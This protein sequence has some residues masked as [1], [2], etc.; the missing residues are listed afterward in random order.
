MDYK[1]Q[2]E[3][4]LMI[5]E[6]VPALRNVNNE[7]KF[8]LKN[9]FTATEGDRIICGESVYTI[10]EILEN[11]KSSLTGY[12]YVTAIISWH[13]ESFSFNS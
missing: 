8:N 12:N 6:T 1:N 11:R 3:A 9:E 10:N 2:V 5:W 4:N 13:T 7:I